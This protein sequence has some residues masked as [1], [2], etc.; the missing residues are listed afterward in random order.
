MERG[1]E[2]AKDLS[3]HLCQVGRRDTTC[4]RTLEKRQ[5]D[6][7]VE[8]RD[9]CVRA[10]MSVHLVMAIM[11]PTPLLFPSLPTT[12]REPGDNNKRQGKRKHKKLTAQPHA[13]AGSMEVDGY[14]NHAAEKQG[15]TSRGGSRTHALFRFTTRAAADLPPIPLS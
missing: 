9:T 2:D 4:L 6:K 12:Q 14:E 11:S 10:A 15:F 8:D 5:R 7:V 1:D 3:S 13:R